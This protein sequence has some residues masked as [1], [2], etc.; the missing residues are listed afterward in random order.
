MEIFALCERAD[1]FKLQA[2]VARQPQRLALPQH[3][4]HPVK[5]GTRAAVTLRGCGNLAFFLFQRHRGLDSRFDRKRAADA[6]DFF[7][8]FGAVNQRDHLR[9]F[10]IGDGLE[11][12]S[13]HQTANLFT[14]AVLF[15]FVDE[16][17]SRALCGFFQ[18]IPGESGG[19]QPLPCQSQRNA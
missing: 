5:I 15:A 7:V 6:G 16:P 14:F 8:H 11:S 12:D 1:V 3:L 18:A 2:Y 9:F 13:R 10:I 17:A 19:E 4:N